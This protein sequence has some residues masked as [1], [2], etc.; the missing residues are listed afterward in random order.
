MPAHKL[1]ELNCR[2]VPFINSALSDATDV[3]AAHVLE[4]NTK[5]QRVFQGITPGHP[6]FVLTPE[7]REQLLRRDPASAEV[8]YPYL[9]GRELVTGTGTPERYLIDFGKRTLIECQRFPAAFAHVESTV[10]PDRRDKFEE[11]KDK[12]GNP[13]PHHKQF[14][15]HWWRLSWG[16][17]EMLEALNALRGGRF[18]A[19]SRVTKRPIFVFVDT[20]IRVGDAL[21]VFA[22]DDDYSFGILQSDVHWRWF[23]TKCSKLEERFRYTPEGVFDTFPWPQ[24]PSFA[25]TRAVAEAGINIRR[26]RERA[27]ADVRGGGL[28]EVYRVLEAPGKDPLKQAHTALDE[29][30]RDAYGFDKKDDVLAALMGLNRDVFSRLG[31]MQHVTAPGVPSDYR[32]D[33]LNSQDRIRA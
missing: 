32:A 33:D 2:V 1:V 24:A 21:Q 12:D 13:R 16:R 20:G 8:I 25:Q 18:I 7:Q 11:G 31:A 29:A 22:F 27:L 26:L 14:L 17:A 10:L 28:R 15:E 9:I 19:C 4:C 6:G 30:V 3:S 5:P 23:V